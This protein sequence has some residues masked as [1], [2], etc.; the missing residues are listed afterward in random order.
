[1][2]VTT[3]LYGALLS[4]LVV[5]LKQVYQFK[6]W[7]RLTA[8]TTMLDS[9]HP[10]WGHLHLINDVSDYIRLV[11]DKI[12]TSG[13]KMTSAWM[14]FFFPVFTVCHPDTA[15][16]LFKSS[17]PKPKYSLG[18]SYRMLLPWLGDGLLISDGKKWERNRR[19]L[20]PAFHFDI[21]KPYVQIYNDVTEIFLEK[22]QKACNSGKSI[23]IY[24]QVSL[25]TLDTMLRCSLSY[26]GHVQEKGDS[27]PY[28][29]AVRRLGFLSIRR[30]M[31]PLLHPNFLFW[32]SPTGREY[33]QHNDYVHE[34]ADEI[35]TSRRKSL[36]KDPNQL[37]K[38]KLDFLDILITAKDENGEGLSDLDIRA[39]VD[40]YL[41][42]GHDT[43]ASAISW[44]I[45]CLAKYPEEQEKIYKEVT[46]VL[47]GRSQLSWEDMSRL[48]Y[49]TMFLKEVMRM[50]SPVPFISRWLTKPMIL[51][52]VEIPENVTVDI[53]IHCINHHPDVWPDHMEFRPSR[54]ED[55]KSQDKDPYTYVP[56]SAG[57]RNCIGQNFALNEE[58][59][60]IGALVKRF[61]VELV[62]GHV[63]EEYPE[64]VMRAKYG[65]KINVKQR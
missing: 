38:S 34:F 24:S 41:F 65:I 62:E 2:I 12:Q 49:T 37:Q 14:M 57:S 64:V 48:K 1:M 21:L 44:A 17:E 61:K 26:E 63:Y 20:T 19:L 53:F 15:K 33:K 8:Q 40:T 59:V 23:E 3:V 4:I 5:F 46:S 16:V 60:M 28:V 56:F 22:L 27:H 9:W 11:T 6:Q 54:F 13:T 18:G 43:T 10:I 42:E 32:L 30:L 36:E 31:N 39:E 52:G 47:D 45:Y 29:Q 35:I 7:R 55:Y 51:D 25:A 50:H 58:R